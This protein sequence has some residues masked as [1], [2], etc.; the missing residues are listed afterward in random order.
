MKLPLP[1]KKT[2]DLE[3]R[4]VKDGVRKAIRERQDALHELNLLTSTGSFRRE[5]P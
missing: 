1:V 4:L 5:N 3:G 2:I